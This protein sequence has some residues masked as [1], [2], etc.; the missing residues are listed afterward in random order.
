MGLCVEGF[1]SILVR[2]ETYVDTQPGIIPIAVRGNSSHE[3]TSV[4][5]ILFVFV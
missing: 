2:V 5:L 1:R 3:S 4:A